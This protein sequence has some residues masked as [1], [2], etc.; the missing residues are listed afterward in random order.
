MTQVG[1]MVSMAAPP[2]FLVIIGGE[3]DLLAQIPST[4]IGKIAV[5]QTAKV[6]VIGIGEVKG[7]VRTVSPAVDIATQTGQARISLGADK[8]LRMGTFGRA[9]IEVGTSCGVSVPLS[10]VLYS[11]VGPVI[12][13]V[14][15]NRVQTRPVPIGLLSGGNV[16]IPQGLREGDLVVRRAGTFLREGD[17][18][19]PFI[20]DEGPAASE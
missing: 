16:E 20:E 6:D 7:T 13:V 5:G 18:V 8:R 3:Y 17:P 2:L 9:T 11:P 12:Q 19:R 10:A 15:N 1:A 14:R 4:R